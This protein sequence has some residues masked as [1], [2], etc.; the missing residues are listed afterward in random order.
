MFTKRKGVLFHKEAGAWRP[1]FQ[2]ADNCFS[3]NICCIKFSAY[4]YIW[5]PMVSSG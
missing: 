4:I 2:N 1:Y 3:V 5:M